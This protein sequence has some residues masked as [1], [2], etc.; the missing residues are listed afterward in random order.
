VTTCDMSRRSSTNGPA[1]RPEPPP[2]RENMA[3]GG[4]K[5]P[6]AISAGP[7]GAI[8]LST[9][10]GSSPRSGLRIHYR[11]PRGVTPR[12]GALRRKEV[13]VLLGLI[14]EVDPNALRAVHCD[15]QARMRAA[16]GRSPRKG[17]QRWRVAAAVK[18]VD[19]TASQA[20]GGG[21]PH[22]FSP[23]TVGP[24]GVSNRVV[25][26]LMKTL[27]S[28]DGGPSQGDLHF[29]EE[30]ARGSELGDHWGTVTH[31]SSL[32]RGRR[33]LR[34]Y[35]PV[36]PP[37]SVLCPLGGRAHLRTAHAPGG[38]DQLAGESDLPRWG[39]SATPALRQPLVPIKFLR[40]GSRPCGRLRRQ[41]RPP[42]GRRLRRPRGP[43]S[44]RL[45]PG[46]APQSDHQPAPGHL[47][48]FGVGAAPAP[49]G[50][51]AAVWR[52]CGPGMVVG[53]RLSASEEVDGL[54]L[55]DTRSI[56][57]ALEAEGTVSL[58]IGVRASGTWHRRLEMAGRDVRSCLG[59]LAWLRTCTSRT[60]PS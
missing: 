50:V 13:E 42:P 38:R 26:L 51:V 25:M 3:T 39:P 15:R 28:A 57:A 23:L 2:R 48:R 59:S 40:R 11:E 6:V 1:G 35:D 55:I 37:P 34:A 31:P 20:T 29:Y 10:C 47:R 4:L 52:S 22:L 36:L 46:A 32:V 7:T 17:G 12:C 5:P 45:P 16:T 9:P 41:R 21:Y 53:V 14:A 54:T 44:P 27:F 56:A 18:P 19:S 43:R 33:M 8:S 49:A 60:F 24:V 30:R 58:T